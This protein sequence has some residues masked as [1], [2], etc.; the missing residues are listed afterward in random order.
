MHITQISHENLSSMKTLSTVVEQ[1]C[2]ETYA[3]EI[4]TVQSARCLYQQS[5]E[6]IREKICGICEGQDRVVMSQLW[7]LGK[8]SQNSSVQ[9]VIHRA[10]A[11]FPALVAHG[12]IVEHV[13][14]GYVFWE[15]YMPHLKDFWQ[16]G[17]SVS[18][19]HGFLLHPEHVFRAN[20][21]AALQMNM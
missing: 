17:I 14:D 2:I 6:E 19:G 9:N 7:A 11:A 1:P 16:V 8:K 20:V 4:E 15:P 21:Q 10:P 3:S 5:M 13:I 12:F 18:N